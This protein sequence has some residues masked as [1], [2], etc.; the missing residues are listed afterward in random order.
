MISRNAKIAFRNFIMN[1]T[2]LYFGF[3]TESLRQWTA[4]VSEPKDR[5]PSALPKHC[6]DY[7]SMEDE[8]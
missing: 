5:T 2:S 6:T 7:Q 1:T 3:R 4:E 8:V